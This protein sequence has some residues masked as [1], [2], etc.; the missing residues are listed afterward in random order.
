MKASNLDQD[1]SSGDERNRYQQV[2]A[3][4]ISRHQQ[5]EPFQL[6]VISDSMLPFLRPG[7]L[8]NVEYLQ[9]KKL[10]RGD[11][12]VRTMLITQNEM[13]E[14]WIVH[15][16]VG[17]TNQGWLTKGDNRR[18]FDSPIPDSGI[19]GRVIQIFQYEKWIDIQ[20]F[21]WNIRNRFLGWY[22]YWNGFLFTHLRRI[23]GRLKSVRGE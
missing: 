7:D 2:A 13:I 20:Q 10:K 6:R 4:L 21:P 16:L 9:G 12:I 14:D 17:K 22:H 5:A 15:R 8:I 3:G 1:H 18:V 23:W 19:I 11:I